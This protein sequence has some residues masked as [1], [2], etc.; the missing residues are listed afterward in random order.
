[1]NKILTLSFLMLCFIL[2]AQKYKF[3][4]I[5]NSEIVRENPKYNYKRFDMVNS[6]NHNIYMDV[7]QDNRTKGLSSI[8]YDYKNMSGFRFD[9]AQDSAKAL[10]F[11]LF[12]SF[13]LIDKKFINYKSMKI[14]KIADLKYKL[15]TTDKKMMSKNDLE[16]VITLVAFEADLIIIHFEPL[17]KQ[18]QYEIENTI[19]KQLTSDNKT[20]TY[21]IKEITYKYFKD[22]Y[23]NEKII[24]EKI[25]LLIDLNKQDR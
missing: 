2:N 6:K 3:Y 15:F 25:E 22:S 10:K 1:M 11:N 19:K 20:G 13:N 7:S 12:S 16:I 8:L 5:L 4:Y 17:T 9:I 24:P 14:E 23:Y 18:Q 21:Y